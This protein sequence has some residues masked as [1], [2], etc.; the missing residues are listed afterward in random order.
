MSNRPTCYPAGT[1]TNQHASRVQGGVNNANIDFVHFVPSLKYLLDVKVLKYQ[2][3]YPSVDY[4]DFLKLML[5]TIK[6]VQ[7]EEM[8]H[9]KL[10]FGPQNQ[11][12][13]F[14]EPYLSTIKEMLQNPDDAL[15]LRVLDLLVEICGISQEHL[16]MVDKEGLLNDLFIDLKKDDDVLVQLNAI[17]KTQ[18]LC[19]INFCAK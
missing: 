15:K 11:I 13:I 1:V 9:E 3:F 10:R 19:K 17:G 2:H 7:I 14:V 8:I 4:F 18:T 5:I 12:Q 16:E 6:M